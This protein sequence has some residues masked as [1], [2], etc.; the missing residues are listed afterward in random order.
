[1]PRIQEYLPQENAPAPQGAMSPDLEQ[2]GA[3]GRGVKEL[4]M[5]ITAG[6]DYVHTRQVQMEQAQA[7]GDV[8]SKK[9]DDL[10]DMQDKTQDGT[11]DNDSYKQK[12]TDWQNDQA[13][14]YTTTE[15]KNTFMRQSNRMLGAMLTRGNKAQTTI[16][17]NN[18]VAQYQG[19]VDDLGNATLLAPDTFEDNLG[20]MYE[21]AHDLDIPASKREAFTTHG[22]QTLAKQAVLGAARIDPDHAMAMLNDPDFA[23][24]LHPK[25]ADALYNQVKQAQKYNDTEDTR[26]QTLN[27]KAMAAQANTYMTKNIPSIIN[28]QLTA[29]RI[30]TEPNGLDFTTRLAMAEKANQMLNLTQRTSPTTFADVQSRMLLPKDDPN[31]IVDISQLMQEKD[32]S[33]Q[34]TKK[35]SDWYLKTPQGA[36]EKQREK[37]MWDDVKGKL[38]VN[39]IPD[40]D[41]SN[42]VANAMADYQKAKQQAITD[43]DDPTELTDPKSPNYFAH[44]IRATSATEIMQAQAQRMIQDATGVKPPSGEIIHTTPGVIPEQLNDG[45]ESRKLKDGRTAIYDKNKKFVRWSK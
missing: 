10:Q 27:K 6:S 43:G 41:R 12:F 34:D 26:E 18:A 7:F 17:A 30:M 35:L 2:L 15:G 29:K 38:T 33:P 19:N 8:S 25:D 28:G 5:G 23:T 31:A 22:E 4:G 20:A 3:V 16:A 39:G 9:V 11:W 32:L 1:M 44:Q 37:L 21:Q 36:A 24:Y 40:Q 14:K 42:R 13:D 45:E